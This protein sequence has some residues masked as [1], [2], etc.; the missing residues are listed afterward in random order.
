MYQIMISVSRLNKL[1]K[2]NRG[3]AV[4]ADLTSFSFNIMEVL[5]CK[6]CSGTTARYFVA[7]LE[8]DE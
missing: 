4:F 8:M 7:S 6:L 3:P 5:T 2:N 1:A